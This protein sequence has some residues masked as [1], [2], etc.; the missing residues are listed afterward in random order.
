MTGTLLFVNNW[1]GWKVTDWLIGHDYEIAGVVLHPPDTR[2][3][4]EQILDV[5]PDDIEMFEARHLS[6][7]RILESI[8]DLAPARGLSVLFDHILEGRL[9]KLFPEGVI[10]LHPA[11]LP[12]NRG[13][14]PN[15]WSLVEGTP[16][17]TSIHFLDE[18]ID[19]GPVIARKRV[20]KE[21]VDTG[22]TLYRKLEQASLELFR[23]TWPKILERRVAPHHQEGQGGTYHRTAD[24]E[25]IDEIELDKEYKA[26]HLL[27]I[28]RARTFPPYE[29]AYFEEDGREVGIRVSL[30]YRDREAEGPES[31]LYQK[32]LEEE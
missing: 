23:E 2:A 21:P 25:E 18:G 8:N 12:Y 7:E 29:G 13:Q 32:R 27:N 19:T 28:L 5:L 16:A 10:N 22:Q 26:R 31:P 14:Y 1:L 9:I 3:Y 24:V 6:D 15:V 11:Y 17:G 20:E 30:H 4:G